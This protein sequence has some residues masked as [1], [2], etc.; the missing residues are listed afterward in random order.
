MKIFNDDG[1]V[2]EGLEFGN[3]YRN[4]KP[5]TIAGE[6]FDEDGEPSNKLMDE[7]YRVIDTAKATSVAAQIYHA[8]TFASNTKGNYSSIYYWR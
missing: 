3:P 6:H 7:V 1:S 2:C 8:T 5:G 4:R